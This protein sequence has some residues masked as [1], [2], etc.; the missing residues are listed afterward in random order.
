MADKK[1]KPE[2]R[3]LSD[4]DLD[5]VAGGGVDLVGASVAG[6]RTESLNNKYKDNKD[7]GSDFSSASPKVSD[8]RI[9]GFEI[10]TPDTW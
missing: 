1:S 4:A 8:G 6:I 5:K 7:A 9:I 3:E 10:D 2:T